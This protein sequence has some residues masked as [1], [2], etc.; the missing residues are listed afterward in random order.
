MFA[1]VARGQSTPE[2][3]ASDAEAECKRIFARWKRVAAGVEGS[4]VG[5]VTL[6][7]AARVPVLRL[8]S[9]EPLCHAHGNRRI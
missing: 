1:K 6:S 3:A 8:G 9:G 5:A 4:R 7:L 2:Q